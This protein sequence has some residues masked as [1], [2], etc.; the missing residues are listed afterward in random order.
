[1]NLRILKKLSKRA[2]PYLIALGDRQVHFLAE[3]NDNYHGM[4]IRDR[5]CW[6]RNPCHPSREPGWCNFGD[7]PV[8]YV[9]ARK[10]YRYVMRPPHHPLKGTPMVGGMSGGEQPEWDEICAYACL[11]S[12]VCSHFTDWSNWERP[13]PTRDLTTVSKIFAAA[14]DMVAERMAA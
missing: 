3:R 4:T 5:T 7:E 12:W 8:L 6:E 13:I 11:A 10:G 2:M 9:V 1:M 14:D